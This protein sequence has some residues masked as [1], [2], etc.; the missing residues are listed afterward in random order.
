MRYALYTLIALALAPFL[1]TPLFLLAIAAG[2]V[3]ASLLLIVGAGL[4][5]YVALLLVRSAGSRFG[6]LAGRAWATRAHRPA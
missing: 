2:P 5:M 3:L 1:L 4:L 6:R